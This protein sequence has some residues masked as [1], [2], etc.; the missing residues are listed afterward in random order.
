M[1]KFLHKFLSYS[2]TN[3]DSKRT[4]LVKRLKNTL[5][6]DYYLNAAAER[7]DTDRMIFQEVQL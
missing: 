5:Y 7:N 6:R 1:M 4:L 2:Y 3:C